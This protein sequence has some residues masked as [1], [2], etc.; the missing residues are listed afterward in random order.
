MKIIKY[1][2]PF[3]IITIVTL[4]CGDDICILETESFM[5]L[6]INVTDTTLVDKKYLENLS[7]YSPEWSDS[8]HYSEEGSSSIIDFQLSPHNS[9]T[10]IVITSDSSDL[11]D[12]VQFYH[13]NELFF[14]SPECGFILNYKIDSFSVTNNLIDS[15]YLKT[16][17][18]TNY[19]N[20][21]FEIYIL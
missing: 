5:S 6:E 8:I 1:I 10:T 16:D 4:S 20:G 11:K 2:I 19:V 7:I 18:I 15:I 3:L 14:L 21:L 9:N 17:K 13:Q 12:T